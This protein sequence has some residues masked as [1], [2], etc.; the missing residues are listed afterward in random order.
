MSRL[1]GPL[2]VQQQQLQLHHHHQQQQQQ[3]HEAALGMHNLYGSSHLTQAYLQQ[4]QQQAAQQHHQQGMHGML[5]GAQ[6]AGRMVGQFPPI[7]ALPVG[8]YG[9]PVAYTQQVRARRGAPAL[10][11]I[12]MPLHQAVRG[13]VLQG[14]PSIAVTHDTGIEQIGF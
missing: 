6:G 5:G 9:Q 10:G 1:I 7:G 11:P 4:Q 8:A 14:I 12:P 2:P 3:Q 13:L